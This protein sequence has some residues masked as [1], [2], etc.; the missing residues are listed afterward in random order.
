MCAGFILPVRQ[1]AVPNAGRS[2]GYTE[3]ETIT[4]YVQVEFSKWKM[5]IKASSGLKVTRLIVWASGKG[6]KGWDGKNY[7]LSLHQHLF[8]QPYDALD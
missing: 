1:N 8:V 4:E 6:E 3:K 2:L 5:H 7:Y